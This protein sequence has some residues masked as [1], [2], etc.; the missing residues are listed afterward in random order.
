MF[1]TFSEIRQTLDSLRHENES[2]QSLKDF[3]Q[4]RIPPERSTS[5]PGTPVL[6]KARSPKAASYFKLPSLQP[7]IKPQGKKAKLIHGRNNRLPRYKSDKQTLQKKSHFTHES[8]HRIAKSPPVQS[9][10]AS[11]PSN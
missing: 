1:G 3:V 8:D 10:K 2:I 7:T 11:L 9:R 4:R 5:S 6:S